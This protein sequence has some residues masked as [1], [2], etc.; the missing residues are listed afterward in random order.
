MSSQ[1]APGSPRWEERRV[2]A[3]L[4]RAAAFLLPVGAVVAL[5][6]VLVRVL[7]APAT[8]LALVAWWAIFL[9]ASL[10]TLF[11]FDRIAR[12]L[13]PLSI[14]LGM[15][16]LFPDRA[17][18]RFEVARRA[19]RTRD[20]KKKVEQARE[21]GIEDEP[22]QAAT[23]VLALAAA[24]SAHDRRTR[25]HSERVRAFIDLLAGEL[26]LSPADRDR[27]R[28]AGLL[29]DIGKLSVS[30]EIL[31]KPGKPEPVEW[32]AIKR[33]PVEGARLTAPLLPFLG[34][35]AGT[36]EHHH[37][38]FDGT[39]YPHGL[40]AEAISRGG[41]IAAIA[42]S[43][44]VMTTARPYK[45]P[46]TPA[47]AREELARCAGTHFDPGLVRAFLNISV[48]RLWRVIGLLSWLAQ[49]P[50]FRQL[51]Y[52]GFFDRLGRITAVVGVALI[53]LLALGVAGALGV[54]TS[55]AVASPAQQPRPS[56]RDPSDAR[57]TV[58][59]NLATVSWTAVPAAGYSVE[60]TRG[61]ADLPD[62]IV[63]LPGTATQATS[64]PLEPG[65]WYFHLRTQGESG[66]WTSTIHL[67]FMIP[68][69]P[70]FARVDGRFDAALTGVSSEGAI[71]AIDHHLTW[72]FAPV[73]P[74]G[75]CDLHR[76]EGQLTQPFDEFSYD[77]TVYTTQVQVPLRAPC[78]PEQVTI[79]FRVTTAQM[80][81]GSWRAA[82]LTGTKMVELPANPFG[83]HCPSGRAAWS[84]VATPI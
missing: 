44:E 70:S 50:V 79:D 35:W 2:L 76:L 1:E 31:N 53:G 18:S 84:F 14:L 28:W 67:A 69:D 77:G 32:E 21:R 45:H 12:R 75:P 72:A 63:D 64:P 58:E 33:H 66:E 30:P 6:L 13:L 23:T 8:D 41:R 68:E 27:L 19:G 62:Q 59:R 60:W 22:T 54:P 4:V 65:G 73:C 25:G 16:M 3:T 40:I 10:A 51:S 48:G 83:R 81:N 26:P 46:I 20:L 61:P 15:T 56:V 47:A 49:F 43:F 11:F 42:D 38:K 52:Y 57:A 71:Q 74:S 80:V 7:P 24:L 9:A 5:S 37:E 78:G 82:K 39:G 29:H 17:P 55:A 36:I 34:V